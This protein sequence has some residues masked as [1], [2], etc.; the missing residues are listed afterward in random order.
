MLDAALFAVGFA[1]IIIAAYYVTYFIS[2]RGLKTRSARDIRLRDRFALSKDKTLALVEVRGHVYFVALTN[3]G[4]AL[5]DTYD[6]AEFEASAPASSAARR[7]S[8]ADAL[9][10]SARNAGGVPGF[11]ASKLS[12]RDPEQDAQA[13][14]GSDKSDK[15]GDDI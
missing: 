12:K 7:M 14:D 13:T 4:A 5:L 8:F 3:G 6:L 9:A 1:V 2:S 10:A 11:I 15:G